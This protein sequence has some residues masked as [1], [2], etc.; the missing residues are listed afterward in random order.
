[1]IS[2]EKMVIK[3]NRTIGHRQ[4]KENCFCSSEESFLCG[5]TDRQENGIMEEKR[6]K[7]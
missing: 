3:S 1:M 6:S 2:L 4:M 7:F 5:F